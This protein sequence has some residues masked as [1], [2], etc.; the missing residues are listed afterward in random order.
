MIEEVIWECEDHLN[1]D[2][3]VKVIRKGPYRAWLKVLF[4]KKVFHTE[5]VS[6]SYDALYGPD[7]IDIDAWGQRAAALV[8]E[9]EVKRAR[10]S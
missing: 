9:D 10:H 6:V 3:S 1:P 8:D 5:E 4:K 2:Y 7:L